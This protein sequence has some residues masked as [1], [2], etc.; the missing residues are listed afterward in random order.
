[1]REKKSHKGGRLAKVLI[2]VL[3]TVGLLSFAAPAQA[4]V[5]N[6]NLEPEI[7]TVNATGSGVN[8][9]A[10]ISQTKAQTTEIDFEF[11]DDPG[12]DGETY[13]TP[14]RTCSIPS[15]A[16]SCSI[17]VPGGDPSTV[18]VVSWIDADGSNGSC[19]ADRQLCTGSS[20][21]ETQAGGGI[22]NEPDNTDVVTVRLVDPDI[23]RID[24]N[25]ENA[26]ATL[27]STVTITCFI[28]NDSGE[29]VS[30]PSPVDVEF[31]SGPEDSDGGAENIGNNTV[32]IDNTFGLFG[33]VTI[34]FTN[35]N[36]AGTDVLCLF[37]DLD[38]DDQFIPSG[39]PRDGGDCDSEP[40]NPD[41][42]D[43]T[44]VVRVTF[45]DG[46][47]PVETCGNG[48]DDDFDGQIDENCVVDPDEGTVSGTVFGQKKPSKPLKALDGATVN[49]S[50]G[51]SDTT[52]GS[53]T[54]GPITADA[55]NQTV[56]TTGS[57]K[58]DN[59]PS[60]NATVPNGGNVVVNLTCTK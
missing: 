2:G 30:F 49:V 23:D 15:G 58:F 52:D 38:L 29:L 26:T 13:D 14:D 4:D 33:L 18:T 11:I 5:F 59:C 27:G 43:L 19:E 24:C 54:F 32:D 44:D 16:L 57:G 39:T 36:V 1:M 28:Y 31:L 17:N 42:A 41:D 7:T 53:G 45:G 46:S 22:F 47:D 20:N 25:P 6:L 21:E 56:S 51:G 12:G 48:V 50:N 55:G 60:K 9:T 34:T 37:A 40:A 8:I 3:P 35:S 10:S